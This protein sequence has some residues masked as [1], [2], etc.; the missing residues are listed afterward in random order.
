MSDEAEFNESLLARVKQL[1]KAHGVT[2]EDMAHALDIPAE[3][4]RKYESRT[5]LPAYLWQKFCIIVGCDLEYLLTGRTR[6]GAAPTPSRPR[7]SA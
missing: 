1:R 4:Y 7:M 3:R 6:K 5:P 2:A